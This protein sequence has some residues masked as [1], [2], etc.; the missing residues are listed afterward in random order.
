[1]VLSHRRRP[2]RRSA[3]WEPTYDI[4]GN[5]YPGDG[6]ANVSPYFVV[7]WRSNS[8]AKPYDADGNNVYGSA[9]YFL[10]GTRFDYPNRNAI[11]GAAY[12]NPTD[13]TTYPNLTSAPS[14]VAG[15]QILATRKA[16]GWNYSVID[17]PTITDGTRD[18]N[19]GLAQTPAAGQP[20]GVREDRLPRRR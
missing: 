17:D 1:M 14:F 15:S 3:S 12:V 11:G 4:G 18:V 8:T 20:G 9:G 5:Y 13:N 16:G 19:W 6:P 10:F 2:P 7:P